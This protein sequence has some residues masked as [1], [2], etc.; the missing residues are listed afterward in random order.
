MKQFIFFFALICLQTTSVSGQKSNSVLQNGE[1][2][3]IG[4]LEK[5]I[6]KIDREY[7]SSLGLSPDNI[8]PRNIALYGNGANGMLPQANSAS[9]PDDLLE[10][11]ILI[12]GESDGKFDEG[13]FI[14]FFGNSPDLI[15]Y[16]TEDDSFLYEKNL[17]SDT[18]FYFLTIKE[19]Q[20]KR[21][22]VRSNAGIDLPK[23]T[24]GQFVYTYELD[25]T[26]LIRGGRHWF[27]E[28]FSSSNL[29]H[30]FNIDTKGIAPKGKIKI[31]TNVMAQSF[32]NTSFD[33]SMNGKSLGNIEVEKVLNQTYAQKG[34]TKKALFEVHSS[35]L[36]SLEN[37]LSM[38]FKY[39]TASTGTSTGFLDYIL[40][41]SE[42]DLQMTNNYLHFYNTTGAPTTLE[43][44]AAS[45]EF[46]IWD[47]SDP[48]NVTE[49]EF[50]LQGSKAVFG[51]ESDHSELVAFSGSEFPEPLFS[52]KVENQN[53]H[54]LGSVDAIFITHDKFL[55]QAK[56][57]KIH[58]ESMIDGFSIHIVTVDQIYNEFSSGMQDVSAIRDFIRFIYNKNT[59]KLKHV[60]LFGDCSYDYKD[61]AINK[62]N[63]VPVYEARNTLHPLYNFSSDDFFGFMEENE[64]EWIENK[65]GDHTLEI[66]I[67]RLPVNTVEEARQVVNKII[68]YD[69]SPNA[70]GEWRNE[71]LFIADDGDGNIH[72]RDADYLAS[73]VENTRNEFNT[74]K[75]FLD[76]YEQISSPSGQSSPSAR[77]AFEESIAEGKI[78]INYT[79]HGNESQ[80]T[81]EK[82][83]DEN[84]IVEL[85][86]RTKLPFLITATC[87]FGNYDNPNRVSGGEKTL[88]NPNG[89]AIALLT[90]TRPVF[91]NTNFIL[92]EAY[93][94]A[95]MK[96]TN[97]EFPSLGDIIKNTK[98]N[99]LEGAKN[100]NFALLGDPTMNLAFPKYD[101]AITGVNGKVVDSSD[102][103]KALGKIRLTGEVRRA[104][105]SIVDSFDG[106]ITVVVFDKNSKFTTLGDEGTTSKNYDQRDALLFKGDASVNSGLFAIE[107][108]VPKNIS[109]V[110]GEGKVSMYAVNNEKSEDANGANIDLKVGG[111]NADAIS[112]ITPPE[113][114]LYI[115]DTD[116]LNGQSVGPSPILLARLFDENG[117]N[118]SNQGFDQ[119]ITITID[120][121]EEI[122]LNQFY[123][124]AL[125]TYQEGWVTYSLSGLE[126]GRH[127]I[128][129]RAYDTYNNLGESEFEFVITNESTLEINDVSLYPNPFVIGM[130]EGISFQFSHDR[131]GEELI[132][133]LEI[134]NLQ[135]RKIFKNTYRFDDSSGDRDQ[136][137][138]NVRD[139]NG[140]PLENGIYIYSISFSS[141]LDGAKNQIH[142]KF[143][144]YN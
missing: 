44:S 93:Y 47:V 126:P 96:K 10:N 55:T 9:R 58:R 62:N 121:Q 65:S 14:L 56:Q 132:A 99:S 79:G 86:N 24:T 11:A 23:T 87:V 43:L 73:Y 5:G 116:F 119:N 112:D 7:L 21:I 98:N 91:S 89:G 105:Q 45:Q 125:D 37:G 122:I 32:G 117:I 130:S 92:N 53:L 15:S 30:D 67:G 8:D 129:L 135:G 76:A 102:T 113:I 140:N 136:I 127:S 143:V 51:V 88:L 110:F 68:R 31:Q 70:F 13:D 66:G 103:L 26:N 141:T 12:S 42:F 25:E 38:S 134:I 72:Q 57:L 52:K 18:T 61:R 139:S 19:S 71:M 22:A 48:V 84:Q 39:N 59:E 64:G 138:W 4:V 108:V 63:Y 34:K 109:Y 33:V 131:I 144:I 35:E 142:R 27:G 90:S 16:N 17:Y 95:A 20:G 111:S 2:F 75:L 1:W 60:L 77:K 97:G 81:V 6:Y 115:N 28:R 54:S 94:F 78:I 133:E 123:S 118:I 100:R 46:N 85:K 107:F 3:K 101:L 49:Q 80:L 74:H 82:I 114:S 36:S 29:D 137:L 69:T 50:E 41:Q 104:D 40:L 120:D 124:A 128:A 106:K 83:I